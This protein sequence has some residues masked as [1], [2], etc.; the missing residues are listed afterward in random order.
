MHDTYNNFIAFF[1]ILFN[2]FLGFP[3]SKTNRYRPLT[4]STVD[5]VIT[6]T[7]YHDPPTA[8]ITVLATKAKL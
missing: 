6:V 7:F 4:S 2:L 5:I 1:N 3:G 8:A